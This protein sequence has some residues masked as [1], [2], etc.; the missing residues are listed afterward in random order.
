[1]HRHIECTTMADNVSIAL[2]DI[3]GDGRVDFALGADWRPADTRTSGSLQWLARGKS[4][5]EPWTVHPIATEPTIHRIRFA[6]LDGDGREELIVVPLFCRGSTGPNFG[7][8]PV[9]ILVYQIP[10]D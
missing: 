5:S 2:A 1:M 10:A 8:A 3:D 9:P 4:A 7:E 6:D